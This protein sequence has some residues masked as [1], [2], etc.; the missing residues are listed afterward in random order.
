MLL[1]DI[2]EKEMCENWSVSALNLLQAIK[3]FFPLTKH[4]YKAT[5]TLLSFIFKYSETYYLLS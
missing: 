2:M 3:T 5:L 1:G 4:L